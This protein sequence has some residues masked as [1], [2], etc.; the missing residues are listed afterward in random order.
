VSAHLADELKT[1]YSTRAVP[2]RKGDSVRVLR[3]EFAGLEGKVDTIDRANS[4]VFVEG[5]TREKTP[6]G[7]SSRL[8]VHSSKV[9]LTTLNLSDKWRSSLLEDKAKTAK[10]RETEEGTA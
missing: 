6:G 7:T 9:I 2:I 8:S 1:R 5:M 3:G 10:D 4:R